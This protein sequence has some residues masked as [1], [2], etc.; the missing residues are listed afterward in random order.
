M[1]TPVVYHL[2][3][4][5]FFFFFNFVF[6][7]NARLLNYQLQMCI[8]FYLTF[9]ATYVLMYMFFKI[10]ILSIYTYINENEDIPAN[11]QLVHSVD[12]A[13]NIIA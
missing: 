3:L 10:Q 6:S 4:V 7:T 1:N 9:H 2:E 5:H 11:R 12:K 13:N 8:N